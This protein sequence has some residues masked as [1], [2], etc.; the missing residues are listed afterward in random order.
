MEGF[1]TAFILAR[2]EDVISNPDVLFRLVIP[3]STKDG[4]QSAAGLVNVLPQRRVYRMQTANE[5]EL[6]K[7]ELLRR[8]LVLQPVC[9]TGV[10]CN[11]GGMSCGM[12]Y[13]D[14]NWVLL[15]NQTHP[16]V[17]GRLQMGIDAAKGAMS[18]GDPFVLQYNFG[19]LLERIHQELFQEYD[20]VTHAEWDFAELTVKYPGRIG[21]MPRLSTLDPRTL[22]NQYMPECRELTFDFADLEAE[23]VG[24][25]DNKSGF[26][27]SRPIEPVLEEEIRTLL[28][29]WTVNE[30]SP[31]DNIGEKVPATYS[32]AQAGRL[33]ES[34]RKKNR[35]RP[36]NRNNR[37]ESPRAEAIEMTDVHLPAS[38]DR[39]DNPGAVGSASASGAY[40]YGPSYYDSIPQ[41][42]FSSE[43]LNG[44]G[45]CDGDRLH[46]RDSDRS[47]STIASSGPAD[48]GYA[49]HDSD[50]FGDVANGHR[51]PYHVPDPYSNL[52]PNVK[53]NRYENVHVNMGYQHD[54]DAEREA[55]KRHS[56]YVAKMLQGNGPH[57]E[58]AV[59]RPYSRYDSPSNGYVATEVQVHSPH[60]K[61]LQG[62][63]DGYTTSRNGYGDER[64]QVHSPHGGQYTR[65]PHG[66]YAP[67]TNY[68][69]NDLA[70]GPKAMP[71]KSRT[72]RAPVDLAG[73][74]GSPDYRNG[75]HQTLEATQVS[76]SFI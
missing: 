9:H 34:F 45:L 5:I 32:Y 40:Q 75:M 29:G 7:R 46:H 48:S 62:P 8:P 60:G 73:A 10:G 22:L 74:G 33:Y 64:A 12:C 3:T 70:T 18:R 15:I 55:L 28:P 35:H 76:E 25:V 58:P 43:K 27:V 11:R 50:G 69:G 57:G 41:S 65:E 59:N 71:R 36:P 13:T 37:V 21:E 53:S 51:K 63:H 68:R 14:V 72:H 2:R 49:G 30:I 17:L 16:K 66:G 47:Q 1:P 56:E 4:V 19:T 39:I 44:I 38:G 24:L 6:F 52:G 23:E 31:L 20:V 67:T 54:E 42:E 26:V 61:S